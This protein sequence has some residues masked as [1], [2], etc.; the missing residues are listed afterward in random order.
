M[1]FTDDMYYPDPDPLPFPQSYWV[2]PGR[3]MAGQYPGSADSEEMQDKL[4]SMLDSGIDFILNLMIADERNC[5]RR[6]TVA[7][8][9]ARTGA[10]RPRSRSSGLLTV[11][12]GFLDLRG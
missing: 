8:S 9:P 3:F 5:A 11:A 6:R 12:M 10:K 1:S 4:G 2:L 7:P